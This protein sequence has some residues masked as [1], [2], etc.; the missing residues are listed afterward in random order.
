MTISVHVDELAAVRL[1]LL[2]IPEVTAL[3]GTRVFADELPGSLAD[4]MP[5]AAIVIND[6]GLGSGGGAL[7]M[8]NNSY[9]PVTNSTKDL[10]CYGQTFAQARR[11]WGVAAGALKDLGLHGREEIDVDGVGVLLYSATP[12]APATMREPQV[13]WPLTFGT[14]NL[15]A[16]ENGR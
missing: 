4:E 16:A 7:N 10:R 1:Y 11:V 5:L 13:D 15:L 2:S 9:M 6:A 3:V 8:S 12:A 14:F